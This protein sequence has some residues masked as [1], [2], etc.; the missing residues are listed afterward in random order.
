M[1]P[2]PLLTAALLGACTLLGSIGL[3][4]DPA[5]FSGHSA[6]L[7]GMGAVALTTVTVAGVLLARGRWSRWMAIVVAA[8]WFTP[9]VAGTLGIVD[10]LTMAAAVTTATVA[11][12]PW[13]GRWLR[14]L[15]ATDSTPDAAV[16]LLL[17][18]VST[19]AVL[20]LSVCADA[21][22]IAAWMLVIW[23]AALA[24]GIAR[25]ASPA[26]W[27]GRIGH[28]PV[29]VAVG[30]ALGLPAAIPVLSKAAIE[31][32]LLWRRDL[33]LAVSPLVPQRVT[34]VA[35]PPELMNP[36]I[37]DAAGLDDRGLPVEDS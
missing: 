30:V 20:G 32:L 25:A 6:A 36:A 11:A 26:L 3:I 37:M 12:G 4:L 18:L 7:V 33:Q 21:P 1:P 27:T 13:L 9:A 23:S 29:A 34:S 24:L 22:G 19:P 14:H 17:L 2:A 16:I 5:P 15:A 10:G 35:I 28:L 8:L 31:T